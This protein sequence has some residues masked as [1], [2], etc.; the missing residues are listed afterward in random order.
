MPHGLVKLHVGGNCI[1]LNNCLLNV[2]ARERSD[3]GE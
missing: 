1:W 3:R 2:R